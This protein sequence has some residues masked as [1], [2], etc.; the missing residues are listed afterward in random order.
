MLNVILFSNHYYCHSFNYVIILLYNI[1]PVYKNNNINIK[2]KLFLLS[3][4]ILMRI[5]K[6]FKLLLFCVGMYKIYTF[7]SIL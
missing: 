4:N 2:K 5:Y 1:F 3:I 7:N 6:H